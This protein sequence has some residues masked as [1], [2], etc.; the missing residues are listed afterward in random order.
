MR[1]LYTVAVIINAARRV[2]TESYLKYRG[3]GRAQVLKLEA[4]VFLV[5]F[6]GK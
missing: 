3:P 5:Y 1:A 4:F 2:L 6:Q